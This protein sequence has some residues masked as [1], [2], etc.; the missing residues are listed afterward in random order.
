MTKVDYDVAILELDRELTLN[1]KAQPISI[2]ST[3]PD[4]GAHA[5]YSS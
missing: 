3:E 4:R 5:I 1:V 2:T